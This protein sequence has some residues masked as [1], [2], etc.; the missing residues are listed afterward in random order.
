MLE[1]FDF[2]S[3]LHNTD[4]NDG[5]ATFDFTTG[6]NEPQSHESKDELPSEKNNP[7]NNIEGSIPNTLLHSSTCFPRPQTPDQRSTAIP[8]EHIPITTTPNPDL[9]DPHRIQNRIAQENYRKK[10][11]IIHRLQNPLAPM[12]SMMPMSIPNLKEPIMAPA[13]P[14]PRNARKRKRSASENDDDDE[15]TISASSPPAQFEN[16]KED[17]DLSTT[18]NPFARSMEE[19]D[20]IVAQLLKR[21]TNITIPIGAT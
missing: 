20:D 4:D 12:D 17:A 10:P 21:W 11:S 7:S 16:L 2:D 6:F 13:L 19:D 1:N 14:T 15:S 9:T 8:Q 18:L 3:F 5:F